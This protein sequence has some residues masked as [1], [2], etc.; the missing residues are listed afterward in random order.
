MMDAIIGP[1]NKITI[2][3]ASNYLWATRPA[4][5]ADVELLPLLA[6]NPSQ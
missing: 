1:I 2:H 6:G 5:M 4:I 3:L